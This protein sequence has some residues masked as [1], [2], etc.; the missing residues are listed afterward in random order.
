MC[1]YGCGGLTSQLVCV[2]GSKPGMQTPSQTDGSLTL[3]WPH[4]QHFT[5]V[6]AYAVREMHPC[7]L[8]QLLRELEG[9]VTEGNA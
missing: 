6:V 7:C 4:S 5:R 9:E 8:I 3:L 2:T 1:V